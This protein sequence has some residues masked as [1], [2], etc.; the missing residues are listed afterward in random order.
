[1]Q[2]ESSMLNSSLEAQLP[3][4]LTATLR[5]DCLTI[6]TRRD[7]D[8]RGN[9]WYFDTTTEPHTVYG[10]LAVNLQS[11][12]WKFLSYPPYIPNPVPVKQHL[13]GYRFHTSGE[14]ETAVREWFPMQEPDLYCKELFKR[15]IRSDKCIIELNNYAEKSVRVCV[16]V[17]LFNKSHFHKR[18]MNTDRCASGNIFTECTITTQWPC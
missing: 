9:P 18:D 1:M 13:N 8:I 17:Q 3:Q 12:Q 15:V 11:L 4:T 10:R 6:F 16:P 7:L 2:E 14:E 5:D